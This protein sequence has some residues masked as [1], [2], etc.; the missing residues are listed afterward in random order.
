M[1]VLVLLLLAA[2]AVGLFAWYLWITRLDA[3][4]ER[5]MAGVFDAPAQDVSL[6]KDAADLLQ[7][8]ALQ[9]LLSRS[10]LARALQ[11]R[12]QRI[13]VPLGLAAFALVVTLVTLVACVVT[14][15]LTDRLYL[16][17]IPL[18]VVPSITWITLS[19]LATHRARAL[20]LQLPSF[21]TQMITTLGAGGTPLAAVRNAARNA[22]APLGPSM[23]ELIRRLEIGAPPVEVWREWA[24][25]WNSP[26]CRLLS[27]ALR[28]KWDAGG[29]MSTMLGYVLDQL[30]SRRRMEL[31]ILTLTS[32]AR[33]AA[34]VLM[35]LPFV[36][37][38]ITYTFNPDL[39]HEM[40]A[41]PIG[42]RALLIAGVLMVFGFFWLRR[43][44]R[45][46]S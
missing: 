26:A 23:N 31:R 32:Q 38:F 21:V 22:P 28:I 18:L 11:Q 37:G 14:Y 15:L 8:A 34:I 2:A 40:L 36:I 17:L 33:L 25:G 43:I 3:Q 13:G 44:A 45:L 10:P 20:E 46:E 7:L 30:E 27:T 39:F 12:L 24:E 42:Q 9:R 1:G 29:E 19:M 16:A 6:W 4:R 41:D 5:L 35:A